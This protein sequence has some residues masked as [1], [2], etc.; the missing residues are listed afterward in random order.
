MAKKKKE[1]EIIPHIIEPFRAGNTI[2]RKYEEFFEDKVGN[3]SINT[4]VDFKDKKGKLNERFLL[5]VNWIKQKTELV[6]KEK[7]N[8]LK[9]FYSPI[10]ELDYVYYD[11]YLM[12]YF[13]H[14]DSIYLAWIYDSYY[15][16]FN[17][18]ESYMI[19]EL[20]DHAELSTDENAYPFKDSSF[21]EKISK[22]I[23]NKTIKNYLFYTGYSN[24]Q[25]Q[26]SNQKVYIGKRAE[27]MCKMCCEENIRANKEREN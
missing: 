25:T 24:S 12:Y 2:I 9:D 23:E 14:K 6:G 26:F 11:G 27:Y 16:D 19:F 3:S 10:E 7:E 13:R 17:N 4:Y 20:S 21:E 18:N 8:F 1:K 22:M 5:Y 15:K